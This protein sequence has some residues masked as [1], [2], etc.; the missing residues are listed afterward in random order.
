M[1]EDLK[2]YE[3]N[4]CFAFD[5][6]LLVWHVLSWYCEFYGGWIYLQLVSFY[7][8][9][10]IDFIGLISDPLE[11]FQMGFLVLTLVFP[12]PWLC[13]PNKGCSFWLL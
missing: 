4:L 5:G 11:A 2:L 7:G 6:W 10:I 9:Y 3:F 12:Q 8:L 13:H 1:I